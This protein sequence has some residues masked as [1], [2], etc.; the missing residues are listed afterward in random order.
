L[1]ALSPRLATQR[2]IALEQ[3]GQV[4]ASGAANAVAANTVTGR[5]DT[6]ISAGPARAALTCWIN[7]NSFGPST[8][9]TFLPLAKATAS[10]VKDPE[11]TT[12]P[13]AA[14]RCRHHPV[15]FAHDLH[16]DLEGLPVLALDQEL[17]FVLSRPVLSGPIF[18]RPR[19]SPRTTP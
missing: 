17:L 5:A 3:L 16:A 9:R 13:P 15:E 11:V 2:T 12:N 6:G 10:S 14:P 1:L 8:R 19:A 18:G 4:V 7:P